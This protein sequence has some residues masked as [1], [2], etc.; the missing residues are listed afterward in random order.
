[1]LVRSSRAAASVVV[2]HSFIPSSTKYQ[3]TELNCNINDEVLV[4]GAID[5]LLGRPLGECL[6][7]LDAAVSDAAGRD[8]S[9]WRQAPTKKKYY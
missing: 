7:V 6:V 1:M 4:V 3:A 2:L 8:A 5:D 9:G